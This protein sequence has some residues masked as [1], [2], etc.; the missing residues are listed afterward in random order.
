VENYERHWEAICFAF[1]YDVKIVI[2]LLM[3][4]FDQ[5]NP[6]S[7]TCVVAINVLAF[8]FEKKRN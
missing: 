4:C 6:I 5:L 2:T 8:Q 1:E 7:Q 3:I